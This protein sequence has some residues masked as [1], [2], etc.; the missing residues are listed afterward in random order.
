MDLRLQPKI[1]DVEVP[2]DRG[3]LFFVGTATVIL[4]YGGYT[5]LTDPNF[6]H[7][8]Q[9]AHLGYGLFSRRRTEPALS[10]DDLPPIDFVLL[11]HLHGDHF[12]RVAMRRLPHDLPI[13]TTPHAARRLRRAGFRKAV[14]LTRWEATRVAKPGAYPLTI[15]AMP[16]RHGPPLFSRLLPPVIG[17]FLEFAG[18]RPLRLYVSGDTIVYRDLAQIPLRKPAA[19]LALLHLGGTRVLGVLVTMDAAEGVRALKLLRPRSAVPIHYDDY[20][21]FRS[22][23][24]EFRQAVA[25]AGLEERVRCVAR[26]ETLEF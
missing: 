25:R 22:P 26:G 5:I 10:I 7:K 18:E 11:S 15:T 2:L 12:D 3:S 23:L 24:S 21:V 9:L 6:L 4:R 17:S 19:D 20:G 13:V 14:G 8:G 1:A 16:G